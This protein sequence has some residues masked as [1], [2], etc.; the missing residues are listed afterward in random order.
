MKIHNLLALFSLCI[1]ACLT[2]CKG[3]NSVENSQKYGQRQMV[4]DS[5]AVTDASLDK[6]VS[7]VG[8]NTAMTPGGVLEVQVELLNHTHSP[9]NFD[10]RFEWF[11]ANGMQ[12]NSIASAVIPDTIDSGED[13]MIQ[14]VA[15]NSNCKD[16]RVKFYEAK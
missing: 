14:A 12:V 7:I 11:D 4:A 13:K 2:G 6:K 15:P 8:V 16:F 10:Y 3:V 1:A 5:R 9:K